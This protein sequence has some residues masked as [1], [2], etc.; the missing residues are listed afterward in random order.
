MKIDLNRTY[1]LFFL[2]SF[3]ILFSCASKDKRN[4]SEKSGGWRP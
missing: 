2:V 3:F 1:L 4:L